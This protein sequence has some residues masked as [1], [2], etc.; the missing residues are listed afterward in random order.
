[1]HAIFQ[2]GDVGQMCWLHHSKRQQLIVFHGPRC[3]IKLRLITRT[4][5][6]R[7]SFICMAVPT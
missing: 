3:Q 7:H 6:A 2:N 5:P 1:M 4:Q